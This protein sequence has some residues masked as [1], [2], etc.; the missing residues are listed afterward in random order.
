V[1][2]AVLE[3]FSDSEIVQM[4]SA[5]VERPGQIEAVRAWRARLFRPR[6]R[7]AAVA[8]LASARPKWRGRHLPPSSG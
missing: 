7:R 4:A 3:Q 2:I 1:L 8:A 6:T 5:L